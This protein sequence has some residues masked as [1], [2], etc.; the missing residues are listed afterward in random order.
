[1]GAS[2]DVVRPRQLGMTE[3]EV[4][5]WAEEDGSARSGLA[6]SFERQQQGHHEPCAGGVAGDRH[7]R[8]CDT[9]I[10]QP[11]VRAQRVVQSRG[12]RMLG[13]EAVVDHQ[14]ACLCGG[15]QRAGVRLITERRAEQVAASVQIQ[16]RWLWHVLG[17]HDERW[18]PTG[19]DRPHRYARWRGE[20]GLETLERLPGVVNAGFLG[21]EAGERFEQLDRASEQLSTYRQRLRHGL[22]D[23][24]Q[25]LAG[26]IEK[27]F[28]G[29]RELDAV[30]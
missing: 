22:V 5:P 12:K 19:G 13:S 16:H 24:A 3:P 4:E 30:R 25:Q 15:G 10:E 11:S 9:L 23:V 6:V 26:S 8:R 29:D 7:T 14:H 18:H 20:L 17:R 2:T 21:N 27:R 1:M 28:A